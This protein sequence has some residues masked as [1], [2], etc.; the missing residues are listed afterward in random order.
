M[1]KGEIRE[2]LF[3]TSDILM[4]DGIK[5]TDETYLLLINNIFLCYC[6][7]EMLVKRYFR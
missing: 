2:K 6:G 1:K 7:V 3:I 4:T 5:F